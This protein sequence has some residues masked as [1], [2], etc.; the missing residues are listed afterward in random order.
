MSYSKSKTRDKTVPASS[1]KK[2]KRGGEDDSRASRRR[3]KEMPPIESEDAKLPLLGI[4]KHRLEFVSSQLK[5]PEAGNDIVIVTFKVI[6]TTQKG[7]KPGA[8]VQALFVVG[9]KGLTKKYGRSRLKAMAIKFAGHE[10]DEEAAKADPEDGLTYT[11]LEMYDSDEFEGVLEGAIADCIGTRGSQ[12]KD[13]ETNEPMP[14]EYFTNYAWF[15]AEDGTV[16]FDEDDDED[17]ED[18][19]DEKPARGKKAAKKAA[20]KTA[21]RRRPVDED[22][23]DDDED[24]DD[25]E[26]DEIDEEDERVLSRTKK[27]K[28]ARR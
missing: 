15:L 6:K 10:N 26:E 5:E 25:E 1:K 28:S 19:E 20:K 9:G 11:L 2:K 16:N 21:K 12:R 17:D 8:S 13:K 24:E 18:D 7:L 4:G 23:E 14:G 22:D 27:K 3:R